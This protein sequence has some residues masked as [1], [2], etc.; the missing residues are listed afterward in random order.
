MFICSKLRQNLSEIEVKTFARIQRVI[1]DHL[2][3]SK[4]E[5][6]Q[7]QVSFIFHAECHSLMYFRAVG[8]SDPIRCV[9]KHGTGHAVRC[10]GWLCPTT[11][12]FTFLLFKTPIVTL[13]SPCAL[14][15]VM[16]Q[17]VFLRASEFKVQN[18]I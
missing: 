3:A 11:Y 6:I 7:K 15:H 12:I 17:R 16:W 14:K 10:L 5:I 4:A 8:L 13:W 9:L 1:W 2:L 18:L